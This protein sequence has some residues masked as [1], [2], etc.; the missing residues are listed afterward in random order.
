MDRDNNRERIQKSY[1]EIVF[2][3]LQTSDT[4]STYIAKSYEKLITDEF[5]LPV[6]FVGGEQIE[7][8]DTVFNLN[9]RSDRAREMTQAL[10]VSM[11]KKV[12]AEYPTRDRHFL[13]K[14]LDDVY[15]VAMNTYYK[16]YEGNTFMDQPD[17]KNTLAEVISHNELRQ[18]HLAET[19]KFAHVTKFFNGDKH[20]VFD[21]EK[22]IL[23]PSHKVATYD[24]DPNMSAEEIYMEF[25]KQAKDFDFVV[26]NFANGDMVGHTGKMDAVITAIKKLDEITKA[27]IEFCNKNNYELI[28]T[29]DH[30]NS[31]EM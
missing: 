30:G 13:I 25:S 14:R 27:I 28:I 1:D 5:I 18:L 26:V 21:G 16:E 22:D 29:A 11:D 4:P 15:F 24:L 31:D 23:V 17:I 19:E 9:F 2:G 10:M 7:S 6:S 3:Q 8:G 12:A 20:I